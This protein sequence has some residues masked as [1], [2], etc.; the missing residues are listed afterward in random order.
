M[1]KQLLAAHLNGESMDDAELYIDS[2]RSDII[3]SGLILI[4]VSLDDQLIV[5]GV[6][7]DDAPAGYGECFSIE[8]YDKP[9]DVLFIPHNEDGGFCEREGSVNKVC[10]AGGDIWRVESGIEH[11]QFEIN[12]KGRP[13]CMGIVID[14][15]QIKQTL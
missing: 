2:F 13:Y 1:K 15:S 9:G 7:R 4:Y 8:R 6:V 11:A 14:C 3:S 5:D 12:H 10:V